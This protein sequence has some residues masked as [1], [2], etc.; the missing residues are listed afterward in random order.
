MAHGAT[1]YDELIAAAE[2][3]P[4]GDYG[5]MAVLT[6]TGRDHQEAPV[7][8]IGSD[9]TERP[10]VGA[11]LRAL[12]EA[13]AFE[14]SAILDELDRIFPA[15]ERSVLVGGGAVR[16]QLW[17]QILADAT[18]RTIRPA[19]SADQSLIGAAIL[20]ASAAGLHGSIDDAIKTM[21]HEAP[22]VEPDADAYADYERIAARWRGIVADRRP[23]VR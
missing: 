7:V 16:N 1:D 3:V 14:V 20:A 10:S 22:W 18:G 8:F 12:L 13:V 23:V 4:R 2:S 5:L 19:A 17:M 9:A 21:R 15:S 11:Q 6:P